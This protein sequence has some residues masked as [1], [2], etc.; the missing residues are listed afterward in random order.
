MPAAKIPRESIVPMPPECVFLSCF[1]HEVTFYASMLGN[2]GIRL[3]RAETVAHADFTLLATGATVLVTDQEF[4][5][6]TW[7]DALDMM[8]A[9]HP[10]TA[11]IVC[12]TQN[13]DGELHTARQRAFAVCERPFKVDRL[14]RS[15]QAAHEATLERRLWFATILHGP[16]TEAPRDHVVD[17]HRGPDH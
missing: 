9:S 13:R 2:S 8:A 12:T 17:L 16:S 5:D 3:H 4:L 1:E 7:S 6:G 11:S 15:I 10:L 14:R